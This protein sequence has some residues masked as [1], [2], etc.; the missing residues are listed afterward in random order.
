MATEAVES[1]YATAELAQV[2][3]TQ[4]QHLIE[5]G[6]AW[7]GDLDGTALGRIVT[8]MNDVDARLAEL[9]A[10]LPDLYILPP[11]KGPYMRRQYSK[12]VADGTLSGTV[13]L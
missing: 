10:E 9:A 3:G 11:L 5:Q 13:R 7:Q 8:I 1:A 4:V 6:R 12:K 2:A